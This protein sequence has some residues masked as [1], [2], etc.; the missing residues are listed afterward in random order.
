MV[1]FRRLTTSKRHLLFMATPVVEIYGSSYKLGDSYDQPWSLAVIDNPLGW[2]DNP[3]YFIPI[4]FTRCSNSSLS[5][6]ALFL[7]LA[8]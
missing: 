7:I 2:W 8:R 3:I 6:I 5:H 4:I 1:P